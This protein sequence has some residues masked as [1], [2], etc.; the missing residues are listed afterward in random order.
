MKPDFFNIYTGDNPIKEVQVS[1]S[2]LTNG[3]ARIKMEDIPIRV[4]HNWWQASEQGAMKAEIP[5]YTPELMLF[6][7]IDFNSWQS[8]PAELPENKI[9]VSPRP[10]LTP[11]VLNSFPFVYART[12]IPRLPTT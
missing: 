12:T 2:D 6:N 9:Q 1:I 7:E 3:S 11:I 4:T 8:K 10:A 5:S